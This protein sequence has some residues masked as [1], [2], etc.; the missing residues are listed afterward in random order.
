SAGASDPTCV[1]LI[2]SPALPSTVEAFADFARRLEHLKPS[3]RLA[4]FSALTRTSDVTK[5]ARQMRVL[6][7]THFAFSMTDLT[8]CH[9]AVIAAAETLAVKLAL[10]TSS[11]G[12]LGRANAPD[13]LRLA[14]QLLSL[15]TEVTHE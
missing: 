1:T 7:P 9:G 6:A 5:Q 8:A 15:E 13:P 12:G 4:V 10:V 2:D 3:H 14:E 11:P